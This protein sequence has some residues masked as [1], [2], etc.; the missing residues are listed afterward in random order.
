MRSTPWPNDTL[1]TV[2][3]ARSAAAVHPDD[4][5][6]EHLDAFL[7]AFTHL[8]VHLH[9]VSRLQCGPLDQLPLFDDINCVHDRAPFPLPRSCSARKSRSIALLLG[10]ERGPAPEDPAAAASVRRSAF[11]PPAARCRRGAPKEARPALSVPRTPPAACSADD[12]AARWRTNPRAPT[13]RRRPLPAP[14]RAHGVENHHRRQLASRQHVI[15]NRELFGRERLADALVDPF[16]PAAQHHGVRRA[17]R[18][19]FV[20]A[21][22]AVRI[23]ASVSLP[24]RA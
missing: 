18:L 15:A 21:V 2:N 6:F 9:G 4:H 3:D 13:A 5:A 17:R 10:I 24:R 8:H 23:R 12:P 11:A 22:R 1:R 20:R 7:V 16:I 19:P 14:D